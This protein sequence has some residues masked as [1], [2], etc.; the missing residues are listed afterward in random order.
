MESDYDKNC[1][2]GGRA[3]YMSWENPFWLNSEDNSKKPDWWNE[4]TEGQ[5]MQKAAAS[6]F[7]PKRVKKLE[8]APATA[9]EK[10]DRPKGFEG[11]KQ[12]KRELHLAQYDLTQK[13]QDVISLRLEY[14]I[15]V[16]K[17]AE[18]LGIHRTTVDE[19]ISAAHR[20]IENHRSRLGSAKK[21]AK[22]VPS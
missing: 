5:L 19:H 2:A 12:M 11:L 6:V 9:K 13:Q 22:R 3:N 15:S 18:R 16:I 17:I 20:R 10:R 21:R 1:V 14:G 7:L 4:E 8:E